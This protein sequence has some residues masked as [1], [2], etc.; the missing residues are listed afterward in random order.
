MPC[1]KTRRLTSHYRIIGANWIWTSGKNWHQD[2]NYCQSIFM[3]ASYKAWLFSLTVGP[4][5]HQQKWECTWPDT[6]LLASNK[7]P[8][9][10]LE[11]TGFLVPWKFWIPSV[12]CVSEEAVGE[13]VSL[14]FWH[15][16]LHVSF[17]PLPQLWSVITSLQN[18]MHNIIDD[19]FSLLVVLSL[20]IKKLCYQWFQCHLKTLTK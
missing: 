18:L 4:F 2:A 9:Q 19:K 11:W 5:V 3:L 8:L 20:P 13:W 17:Q 1:N 16:L 6:S 12:P 15:L 14:N 10:H 7:A